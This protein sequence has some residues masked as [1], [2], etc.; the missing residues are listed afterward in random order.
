MMSRQQPPPTGQD[1]PE[2][3]PVRL[4]VDQDS[5]RDPSAEW[6]LSL[7]RETTPYQAPAG[8]KERVWLALPR[9]GSHRPARLL[10]FALAAAA[11]LVSGVCTSAAVAQWPAWLADVIDRI[12][13]SAPSP[14]PTTPA[15][16]LRQAPSERPPAP[17]LLPLPAP[18]PVATPPTPTSEGMASSAR[19]KRASRPA[20]PEDMGPLL[21]AMRALRVERNPVRARVLLTAYLDRHPKGELSEE[22]LVMLIEAAA[23]NGDS[24]APAL[25]ARYLKLYPR[26][27]FRGMVERMLAA[28]RKGP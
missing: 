19:L 10:R 2:Q 21:E 6:A 11:L 5:V 12:V 20:S 8:R 28:T 25:A 27:A 15:N 23:G 1:T 26:G 9:T 18:G 14:T 13:P 4:C 7:L 16:R 22:A 3:D 24:D 17:V